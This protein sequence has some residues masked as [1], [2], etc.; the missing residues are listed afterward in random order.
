MS[1]NTNQQREDEKANSRQPLDSD[2][3]QQRLKA[4]QPLLTPNWVIGTFAIIGAIFLIIGGIIVGTTSSVHEIETRYD[5]LAVAGCNR[6]SSL[7][8]SCTHS[9]TISIDKDMSS[10]V[11]FYYKLSN[12]YQNHRRYVKSRSDVQLQGSPDNTAACDPETTGEGGKILYPC[13]LIANSFFNDS[14]AATVLT[15]AGGTVVLGNSS[16]DPSN[17]LW[18]KEGIAWS[19]DKSKKFIE[20]N[21]LDPARI[22]TVNAQGVKLPAVDDE[23]FIVW[24]RTAGLPNFKKLYRKIDYSFKAGDKLQLRVNNIYP[25]E[26]F[27]GEKAIVLSTTSW[28]GGK[29]PFLGY[30]Y[31]A[32]GAA[33]IVIAIIFAI[34]AYFA[35]RKL[36]DL[37]QFKWSNAAKQKLSA[38]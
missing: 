2:F 35:P 3:Q 20:V 6:N 29:N 34:K 7:G 37:S 32:V 31:L 12:Y 21:N 27:N 15:K 1:S 23:D 13:G 36:G 8:G 28:L 4:W 38:Q 30:A 5:Q 25:V 11:Y 10:P 24:M 26:D 33:C 18:R 19:S 17:S 16:S 22:T 14:Y 9:L